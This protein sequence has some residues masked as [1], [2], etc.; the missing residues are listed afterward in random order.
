VRE[1]GGYEHQLAVMAEYT[2]D[3]EGSQKKWLE[4]TNSWWHDHDPGS[5]AT[6]AW[7]DPAYDDSSWDQIVPAGWWEGWGRQ[8]SERLRRHRL[9]P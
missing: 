6:P 5:S 8:I 3:P 2:R 9:A 1:L 4:Y 7:S